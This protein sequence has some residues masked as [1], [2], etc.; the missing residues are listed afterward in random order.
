MTELTLPAATIQALRSRH[1]AFLAARLTDE[2]ARADFTRSFAR[3][4][5]DL[6]E[7]PLR[8]LVDP[9]AIEAGLA[10]ALTSEAVRGLVA[11][12]MREV[13]RRVAAAMKEDETKVGEYVPD[14]ARDAIDA[15]LARKD[16]LPEPLLRRVLDDEATEEVMRDVLYDALVE[17][18]DSVNPFFA[19][20][21]LPALI[22]RV[23]P[24]GSGTVLKSIGAVRAEFDKR[25]EPEIRK[26]LQVFARKSKKKTGD[27]VV[28]KA[29]DPKFVKLRR[30]VVAYFYE[31]SLADLA[32]ASDEE[33]RAHVDAAATAIASAIVSKE[34]PRERLRAEL[35]AL[36][37]EHGDTKRGAFLE[38]IGVD[39]RPEL[40]AIAALLW[41]HVKL[42]LESPAARAFYERVV[43]DFYATIPTSD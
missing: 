15:L 10:A 20:W 3:H 1:V 9:A 19:E 28:E 4:Y 26:F 7:R 25:L 33:G 21:G 17:F 34:R 5:D 11:P 42:T 12:I 40:D 6:L 31:Q 36:L 13:H 39:A 29:S 23:M 32:R 14:E 16:A 8:E 41:P 35:D 22:K 30:S 38:A 43:W 18:N 37:R 27:F 2:S 24:I